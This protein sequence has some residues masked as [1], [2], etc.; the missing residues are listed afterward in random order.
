MHGYIL[1]RDHLSAG[2]LSILLRCPRKYEYRY[3]EKI[4]SPPGAALIQ[5]SAA[6]R[7]FEGYFHEI[8]NGGGRLTPD[9]AAE[10]SLMALRDVLEEREAELP[11]TDITAIRD[12]LPGL[13]KTYVEQ[14]ASAITPLA[15]EEEVRYVARCGVP[16]LGYLDLRHRKRASGTEGLIDYKIS[17]KRWALP[18]LV[19]SVQA[20]L[21]ALM[22]G[23]GDIEIHNLIPA[24]RKLPTC[25]TARPDG[26]TDVTP[27]LRVLGHRFTGEMSEHLENL[28]ERAAR[29]ITSGIFMPCD[30]QS[31]WCSR[32]W[33]DYFALCRGKTATVYD[34]AG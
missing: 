4:T 29:L 1:P 28:I 34:L 9:Q 6:H 23:V 8:L 7:A 13:T 11:A 17:K 2:S 32:D 21:Y 19:N 20:N 33:C 12:A 18:Q 27:G 26:I 14:V 24:A 10:L 5:G 16:L 15:V 31:W 22:T 3:I 30:P 25:R